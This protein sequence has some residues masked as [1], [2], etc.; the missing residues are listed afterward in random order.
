MYKVGADFVDPEI[1]NPLNPHPN[2][3]MTYAPRTDY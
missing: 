2:F 3:H 1:Q